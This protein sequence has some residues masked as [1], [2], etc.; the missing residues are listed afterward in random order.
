MGDSL[1]TVVAETHRL[2]FL[3]FLA[4]VLRVV[5]IL[6]GVKT[7]D[8]RNETGVFVIGYALMAAIFLVLGG[9]DRRHPEDPSAS[10]M[11]RLKAQ[12]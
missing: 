2:F 10:H 12:Y 1:L 9:H 8:V 11:Q 4:L 6:F 3:G 7:L 5:D